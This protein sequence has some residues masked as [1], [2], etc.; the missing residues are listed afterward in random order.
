MLNTQISLA[1]SS[2]HLIS[3]AH[4]RETLGLFLFSPLSIKNITQLPP[5]D[6]S[7]LVDHS[8]FN[9]SHVKLAALFF[10]LLF[11][12]LSPVDKHDFSQNFSNTE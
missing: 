3:P 2:A 5:L 9:L 11:Y 8:L 4:N 1:L 6:S 12:E 10:S 7:S